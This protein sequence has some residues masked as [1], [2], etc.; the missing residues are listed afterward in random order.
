MTETGERTIEAQLLRARLL[1]SPHPF[2]LRNLADI[3]DKLEAFLSIATIVN[4]VEE[5]SAPTLSNRPLDPVTYV[6]FHAMNEATRT[7]ASISRI[8]RLSYSSPFEIFLYASSITGAASASLA[9]AYSAVRLFERIQ[10][11]RLTTARTTVGLAAY[12]L[13]G[14]E[15]RLDT[16]GGDTDRDVP[17]FTSDSIEPR[18]RAALNLAITFVTELDSIDMISESE[19]DQG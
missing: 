3:P 14:E 16:S 7:T 9:V 13:L 1:D 4:T 8:R 15:L 5:R 17:Q 18:A 6:K 2:F 10:M 19:I 11:A 12:R